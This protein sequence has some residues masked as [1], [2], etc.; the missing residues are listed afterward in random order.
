V[1]APSR[2][3]VGNRNA[4]ADARSQLPPGP[5]GLD[6]DDDVP[7]TASLDQLVA[8]YWNDYAQWSILSTENEP[9]ASDPSVPYPEEDGPGRYEWAVWEVNA[10][11][12]AGSTEVM[13]LV[14]A[15]AAAAPSDAALVYLGAGPLEDLVSMHGLRISDALVIAAGRQ[16][17]IETALPSLRIDGRDGFSSRTLKAYLSSRAPR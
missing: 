1:R 8:A 15:L 3:L 10:I 2:W 4:Q 6:S 17:K 16:P 9:R 12:R 13:D 5:G 7:V 14:E 11:I